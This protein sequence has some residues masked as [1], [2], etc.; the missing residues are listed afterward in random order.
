V[1]YLRK[2]L[3]ATLM[4]SVDA[5]RIRHNEALVEWRC[6]E[7]RS[8]GRKLCPSASSSITYLLLGLRL[9]NRY[10]FPRDLTRGSVAE[11]FLRL[12]VWIPPGHG[13]LSIVSVEYCKTGWSLVQGIPTACGIAHCDR[14]AS[15]VRKRWPTMD[16][17]TRKKKR[18][19]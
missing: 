11:R 2:V 5:T 9:K 7:I 14:E 8:N 1:R 16:C 4:Y 3:T 17:R 19:G 12:W 13:C 6:K 15:T 10:Q 18:I